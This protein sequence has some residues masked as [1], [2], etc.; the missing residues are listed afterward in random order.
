MIHFRASP[1]EE[2]VWREA[3]GHRRFSEW[4]RTALEAQLTREQVLS[5]AP[6]KPEAT[7]RHGLY[8]CR[9]CETGRFSEGN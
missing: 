6:P 5:Q 9:S 3:A 1:H 2:A 4:I 7:C 8:H